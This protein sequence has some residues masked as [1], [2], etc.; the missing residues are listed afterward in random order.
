MGVDVLT[1]P[2]P[3]ELRTKLDAADITLDFSASVAVARWLALDAPGGSRRVSVFLNPDGTDLVV[4]AEDQARSMRL[5]CIEAQYYRAVIER[6]QLAEHL[7]ESGAAA[8]VRTHMSGRDQHT[9]PGHAFRV[10]RHCRWSAAE[11]RLR[12]K[13]SSLAVWQ[14]SANHS[15]SYRAVELAEPVEIRCGDWQICT[16]AGVVRKLSDL[17]E[18]ALPNETGGVLLG[19]PDHLRKMLYVVDTLPSPADSEEWPRS[20]VRGCDGLKEAVDAITHRTG[21]AIAYLGEWHSHPDGSTCEPS[22]ADLV[23]LAWLTD[24]M[25]LDGMPALMAIVAEDGDV[26]WHTA[27]LTSAVGP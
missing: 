27:T 21:G 22:P 6:E 11:R 24:Y 16:D 9:V 3:D 14:T 23:F 7:L 17:R 15:V 10:F 2:L 26:S 8:E 25:F 1:D 5:D 13:G 20:Y 4:M 12:T 18:Q 19:Y